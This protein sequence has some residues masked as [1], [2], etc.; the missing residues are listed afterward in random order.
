MMK[1]RHTTNNYDHYHRLC[2]LCTS[3]FLGILRSFLRNDALQWGLENNVNL[4]DFDLENF[5][6]TVTCPESITDALN[7]LSIIEAEEMEN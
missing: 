5:L 6:A 1:G 7:D 4:D 2:I 3:F